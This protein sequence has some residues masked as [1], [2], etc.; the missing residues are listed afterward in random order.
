MLRAC[1]PSKFNVK[2]P[3]VNSARTTR[4]AASHH[5]ARE[6]AINTICFPSN[7]LGLGLGGLFGGVITDWLGWRAAFLL[8]APIYLSA[9]CLTSYNLRYVTPGKSKSAVEVLKRIDYFGSFT[10]LISVGSLLLFLSMRYN[11]ALP[12]SDGWVFVPLTMAF[13]FILLFLIVEV[14]VASDPVMVPSMLHQKVPV[15][16]GASN[17]LSG[18]C[19]FAVSYFFP[20]WFQ[21]SLFCSFCGGESLHLMPNS[22]SMSTGSMFAGW[23][24][25]KTGRYKAI[26]LIFGIF[27]FVGAILVSRMREDSGPLQSWLSIIPLGF[28]NAV[29]LQT[30]LIALLAH[31]P[32]SQMAVGTGFSQLFRGM[33]QVGGVAISSALFQARLDAELRKR[34]RIPDAEELILKIRQSSEFIRTLEPAEQQAARDAY[35]MSL[36]SVYVLAACAALVAYLVRLPLPDQDLDVAHAQR[37]QVGAATSVDPAASLSS[38]SLATVVEVTRDERDVGEPGMKTQITVAV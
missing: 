1:L 16:V 31:L 10:L 23:M 9:F 6:R 22:V 3:T 12:W 33:G 35:A 15:L 37:R 2:A 21:I 32:E 26:N 34:I 8:Q 27:P 24:M 30:N 18:M 14:F 38:S 11:D 5:G 19:N 28:G 29:V 17:F 7:T 25:H 13:V 4:M 36:K 20:T